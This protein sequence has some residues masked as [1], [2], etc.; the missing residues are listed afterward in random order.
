M[1]EYGEDPAGSG[2]KKSPSK[3]EAAKLARVMKRKAAAAASTASAASPPAAANDPLSA[4]YGQIP[5]E[6]LQSKELNIRDWTEIRDLTEDV[7]GFVWIRGHLA[8]V[9]V[10]GSKLML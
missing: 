2:D 1:E 7:G 6:D 10:K 9:R 4:N 8:S 5:L 3:Q